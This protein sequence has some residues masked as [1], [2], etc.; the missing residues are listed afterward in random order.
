MGIIMDKVFG[1]AAQ[2]SAHDSVSRQN[3]DH[4]VAKYCSATATPIR[5]LNVVMRNELLNCYSIINM[6]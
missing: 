5:F 6:N 3:D 2:L 4:T 1:A